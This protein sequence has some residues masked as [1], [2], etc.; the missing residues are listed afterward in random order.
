MRHHT[1]G[2]PLREEILWTNLTLAE[3]AEGLGA[4]GTSV[5]VTVVTQL[6]EHHGYVKRFARK[7]RPSG[8]HPQRD[9]QFQN[10][11]RLRRQ[12]E[13]SPN[14]ILSMDTKKKE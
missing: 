14:P 10:I 13:D 5:S 7:Q 12:Y 4:C 11:S 8:N 2:D 6:L 9:Q 3:I 1:A